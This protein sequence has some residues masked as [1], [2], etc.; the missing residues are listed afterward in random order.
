L[1]SKTSNNAI[2]IITI[3]ASFGVII[4][5][6]ALFVVLS[7]LSGLRTFS[8]NLLEV[9]DPDLKITAQKGK[10]FVITEDFLKSINTTKNIDE[11]TA[12]IE[13]RVFLQY[14]NKNEIAYIKGVESNYTNVNQ[15]DS[16]LYTGT[17][18]NNEYK[19]LAVIGNGI[20]RKLSLGILNYGEPLS[21]MIPK[22]GTGFINPNNPFYKV[23]VQV[24]GIY[25]GTEEFEN[26]FVF[27]DI[28]LARKLLNLKKD[29]V[30]AIEIKLLTIEDPA[31]LAK[32]L[33]QKLGADFSV[34]TKA[35]LNEVYFK[36]LNTESFIIYLIFILIIIIALFNLIGAIIM[37]IIDKKSNLNTLYNLGVTV[38]K[39]K[40]I[41]VIQGFLLTFFGMLIGLSLG[42]VLV[43]IQKKFGLFMITQTL[44]YPIEFQFK[45]LFI[46]IA[47]ITIL[48]FLASKI[49]SSRISKRFVEL[50]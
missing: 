2:N 26:K 18:L 46:V 23:D 19:N 12:V 21:I 20:S 22:S 30:T 24:S 11:Y 36:V 28:N 29:E 7:G 38:E 15:V 50:N 33:Q 16:T 40:S 41:F 14:S 44:A 6:L 1:F 42:V 49:A 5:S 47:T 48:G 43:L 31:V 10:S 3:I 13:E 39:I 8:Y 27:T 9:S 17:W 37:M 4:G 45:N 32:N 35:Q 34:K 25:S